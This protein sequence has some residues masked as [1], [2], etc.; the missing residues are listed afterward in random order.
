MLGDVWYCSVM[1]YTMKNKR[2]FSR[3]EALGLR[4]PADD[5]ARLTEV[6]RRSRRDM[7]SLALEWIAKG[8]DAAEREQHGEQ[9][10]GA[11][12]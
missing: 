5:K 1:S 11:W 9:Q 12:A 3:D 10:S 8:L 6:A 4:L 7:S 2:A